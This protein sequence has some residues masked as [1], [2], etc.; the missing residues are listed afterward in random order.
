MTS[1][2]RQGNE[3]SPNSSVTRPAACCYSSATR[4]AGCCYSSATRSA[5]VPLL[6]RY[7]FGGSLLLVR[8]SFGGGAATRPLLVRRGCCYSSATRS[9]EVPL[10]ARYSFGGSLLLVRYSFGGGAATRPL[11]VRRGCCYSSATRPRGVLVSWCGARARTCS[12]PWVLVGAMCSCH[13]AVLVPRTCSW[14]EHGKA[15]LVFVAVLLRVFVPLSGLTQHAACDA[16]RAT[17]TT[18]KKGRKS[19]EIKQI[20]TERGPRTR[21]SKRNHAPVKRAT[22][23]VGWAHGVQ[24]AKF[25]QNLGVLVCVLDYA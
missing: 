9:A 10:L 11:L 23:G 17:T 3:H 22:H 6:V 12:S 24:F 15:P 25:D 4:S 14:V 18:T 16:A 7:S 5:E 19:G 2:K 13:S 8:Y 1:T 20:N 21:E